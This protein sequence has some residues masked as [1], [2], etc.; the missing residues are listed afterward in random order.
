MRNQR[1]R[2]PWTLEDVPLGVLDIL[3]GCNIRCRDCLN[4]EANWVKPL[5]EL[6]QELD[7]LQRERKPQCISI[8]GGEVTLHPELVQI[9][10]MVRDRGMFVE[11]LT[12]GVDLNSRLLTQ[13]KQA[14]ANII[15]LH[16]QQDQRRPD[17]PSNPSAED[18]QR[19]R[20]QKAAL[21]RA[22][23]MEV[24]LA[25]TLYPDTMEELHESVDFTLKSPDVSYLLVT[26]WRDVAHLPQLDGA[27]G[28]GMRV[29][30]GSPL[31]FPRKD[32][33]SNRTVDRQLEEQFGFVPFALI[34]SNLDKNDPRWLSYVFGTVHQRGLLSAQRC[35]RPTLVESGFLALARRLTGRHPFYQPQGSLRF[36]IQL[37]L[38]G[39]A[40]GGFIQNLG[41]LLH[42]LKPGAKLQCKRLVFQCP[43]DVDEQ[44][45]VIHCDCCPSGVVKDGRLVP[46]CVSDCV[47]GTAHNC[48]PLAERN[49]R[50]AP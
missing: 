40:G 27:L 25:V 39:L 10:Q 11:V 44:G 18:V 2:L 16:I 30:S 50:V 3:R 46:W 5:A 31:K 26:L 8:V 43:A 23:G 22:H 49:C 17:L 6:E 14:G 47:V 34:G 21:V 15:F 29:V 9:V 32:T 36:G 4:T 19:L 28:K 37:F 13:L 33:L 48:L 20:A 45:R 38:N 24:A 42:S 41:L 35:L 12:N 7:L 1:L